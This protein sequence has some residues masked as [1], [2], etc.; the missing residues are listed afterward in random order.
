[1]IQQGWIRALL[2]LLLGYPITLVIAFGIDIINSGIYAYD[3]AKGSVDIITFLKGYIL[4]NFGFILMVFA[5]R[6]FVDKKTFFS[7]GF[8]W[9]PYQTDA[10]TGFFA[11]LMILFVGSLILVTNQNL[12]FTNAFFNLSNFLAGIILFATIAFTEEVV[13]RGYLLHNLLKSLPKWMA[14]IITAALFALMHAQ[15]NNVTTLSVIN[16]F[17]AGLL[18]GVNYIYTKNLWFAIFF[19][20]SWNFFQGSILGYK[21]SGIETGCGIM[22]QSIRGSEILTGG[23]FGFEGSIVCS[24]L[25]L[26]MLIIFNWRFSKKNIYKTEEV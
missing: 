11:A 22:Q 15:N 16:L 7:L 8:E 10:W 14:L 20:F 23:G 5:F 17:I 13:F 19:H 25:L 1:M 3:Y 9:K 24:V 18:L 12:F 2:F 4:Q 21:V 26:I 6:I